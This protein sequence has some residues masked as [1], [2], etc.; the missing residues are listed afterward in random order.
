MHSF[1]GVVQRQS[2]KNSGCPIGLKFIVMLMRWDSLRR[3]N[4]NVRAAL[5]R[6][7]E[8]A[9]EVDVGRF[10]VVAAVQAYVNV[11]AQHRIALSLG[12]RLSQAEPPLSCPGS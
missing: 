11:A 2:F 1:R 9:G 3:D 8:K 5:E 6:I 7:I 4:A 12:E 10:A